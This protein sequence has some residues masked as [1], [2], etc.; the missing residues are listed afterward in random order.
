M[1][2]GTIRRVGIVG[3]GWLG[4]PLAQ[5]LKDEGFSVWGTT[6]RAQKKSEL[7]GKG[8]ET[9]L[10]SLD[11]NS[12]I[13]HLI[14]QTSRQSDCLILNI[15]PG[16]RKGVSGTYLR[17]VARFMGM[18]GEHTRFVLVSSTSV[19][20]AG[21]GKVDEKS[22]PRPDGP[23]GREILEVERRVQEMRP[24][25]TVLRPGGLLGEDR[26][27]VNYLAGR[28]GLSDGDNPVNLVHRGDCIRIL[29]EIL[30]MG[31]WGECI[32]AVYPFHPTKSKYYREEALKRGLQPPV[33][34][35]GSSEGGKWVESRFLQERGFTY[36]FPIQS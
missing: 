22:L 21:Q 35:P 11:E 24:A 26:H 31:Y 18:L 36:E 12:E 8:I 19:F 9:H 32:H 4:L 34:A 6:T 17:R 14:K 27:P 28:T 23:S 33:F 25:S 1:R 5:H 15:P 30:R 29:S 2:S 16:L 3:L 13:P 7:D 20:G 10:F